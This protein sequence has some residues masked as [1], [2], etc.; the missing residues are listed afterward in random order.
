MSMQSQ[1]PTL[2]ERRAILAVAEHGTIR[3]AAR[4]R[5]LSPHTVDAHLD[6]LRHKCGLRPL[7]QL[8]WLAARRGWLD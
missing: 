7:P 2:Q 4:A 1:E 5:G 6:H 8:V 3:A